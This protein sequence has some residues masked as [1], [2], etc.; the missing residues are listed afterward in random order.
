MPKISN[1]NDDFLHQPCSRCG[2]KRRTLKT[3]KEK[4]K[5]LTGTQIIEF[6][7]IVCTNSAC[8]KEHDK[9]LAEETQKREELR[10]KREQNKPVK[11][12]P[13]R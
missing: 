9:K 12:V 7:Q 10:L 5:T 3:W 1:G 11:K 4:V 6:S 2:S 13:S 8:R